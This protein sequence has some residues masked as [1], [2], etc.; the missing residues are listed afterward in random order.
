[1]QIEFEGILTGREG[2]YHTLLW[3]AVTTITTVTTVTTITVT[4]YVYV[5]VFV[6]VREGDIIY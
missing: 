6:Y 4:V 5:C 1:M 2:I 3:I